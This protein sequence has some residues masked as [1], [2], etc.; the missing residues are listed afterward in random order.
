MTEV[1]LF[2][3]GCAIQYR[4]LFNWATPAGYLASKILMPL[5]QLVFFVELGTY[6]T[7][8]SN[9][10]YFAVGNA[11][12]LTA[13]NGVFGVVMTVG[14]E[15]WFGTLPMLL[16]SPANRVATFLGRALMHILDGVTGVAAGFLLAI[17]IYGLD[18]RH[19]NL[20]LL[21]VCIVLIS[22]TTSG[23]GLMF[24]SISLVTRDVL[25]IANTLYFLL[26]VLCGVNFP[27]SRLPGW[28]QALSWALPMTRGVEAAREAVAGASFAHV[29]GL[30]LGEAAVGAVYALVGYRL[31]RFLENVSRRGGLQEAY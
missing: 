10:L 6:A 7:G 19:A 31:F 13:V 23:L 21:A 14:N 11:L 9:A 3:H 4:A 30:L 5:W 22:V 17:L 27:V 1:R 15:R 25:L 18:L 20:A 8:R 16:G 12:Q 2:L 29:S 24:G 26:L 28:L